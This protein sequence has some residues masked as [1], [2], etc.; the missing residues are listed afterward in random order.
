ML[1]PSV[2]LRNKY[3]IYGIDMNNASVV[4]R[5]EHHRDDVLSMRSLEYNDLIPSI[6]PL[7]IS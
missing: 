4:L 3:D 1:S 7:L 6:K 5:L 2:V